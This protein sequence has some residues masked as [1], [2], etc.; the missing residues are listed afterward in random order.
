MKASAI[1]PSNIAFSKYWGKSNDALT[2]PLNDSISMSLAR[3]TTHTT[4]EFLDSFAEDEVWIGDSETAVTQV[5]GSKAKRVTAQLERLRQE[6][7]IKQ[8]AKVVSKNSFPTGVGIASSASAFAAL[9]AATAAALKMKVTAK[10]LSILTRLAGSGSA[11]RSIYGGFVR[12]K[13]ADTSDESYAEQIADETSW[14]L[15]DAIIITSTKEKN[16]SS[17]E[18]HA[19]AQT[20]PYLSARLAELPQRNLLIEQAILDKNITELG[21]EI[22]KDMISLHFMAMSSVPPIFYWNGATVEVLAAARE[23]RSK[24]IAAYASLD[25]G[26]NVHLI[27]EANQKNK[28]AV[29]AVFNDFPGVEKVIIAPIGPG[30]KLTDMHLF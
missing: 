18:G 25:A 15:E 23:L 19:S 10:E 27:Y 11:A 21:E 7:G 5:N 16:S 8:R 1:A 4:V 26:P 12:W 22:E 28:K 20:S 17:L 29:T 13:H 9:T 30:V 2:L 14:A 6:A 3:V 24:G